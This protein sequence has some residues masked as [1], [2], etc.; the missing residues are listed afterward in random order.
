MAL[1]ARNQ[2]DLEPKGHRKHEKG[3]VVGWFLMM[4][5]LLILIGIVVYA[6]Y[7]RNWRTAEVNGSDVK[8]AFASVRGAS[9]N[10]V[11][12]SKVKTALA[13]SKH[14]SAFE[15]NVDTNDGIVTL[16]GRVPSRE[17]RRIAEEIARDTSGVKQVQNQ[18]TV[19]S[20]AK[21]DP[22]MARLGTRVSDLE[23]RTRLE[24]LYE[25]EET[26]KDD[27][28][29]TDVRD[30]VVI[31]EGDVDSPE[32]RQTAESRAWH[33]GD[34]KD[35]RNN[36]RVKGH[37]EGE[38]ARDELARR[39][40]FE[41]YSSRAFDLAPIQVRSNQGVVIL[42]GQVRSDAEKLLAAKLAQEV[43]GAKSVRNNLSV[44]TTIGPQPAE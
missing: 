10:A 3:G 24:D 22:E 11:T 31:L 14:V 44:T 40:E 29:K 34:I 20:S 19:D 12:T 17:T 6:V 35:V 9:E 26:L 16:Q 33:I 28:I 37:A 30:G 43:D 2:T 39:V 13:L 21:P 4:V 25:K 1:A 42:Q 15:I 36:L 7:S 27:K 18:L 23:F 38:Q 8:Q 5:M 41:L 32:E